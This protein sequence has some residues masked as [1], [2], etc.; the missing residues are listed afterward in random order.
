MNVNYKKTAAQI[1]NYQ[2]WISECIPANLK[3]HFHQRL[4]LSG[5]TIISFSEHFFENQGYTCFWLLA[6]SHLAIHTFPEEHK[7]YVELS[8]CN[9][10]KL[11]RFKQEGD[12]K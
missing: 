12:E 5:F 6:E 2:E 3:E 11:Y 1:Y 9:S 7:T 10:E 4:I 8:S